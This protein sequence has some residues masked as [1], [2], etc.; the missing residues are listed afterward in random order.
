MQFSELKTLVLGAPAVN[1][2]NLKNALW[3]QLSVPTRG[4]STLR[5]TFDDTMAAKVM[6]NLRKTGLIEELEVNRVKYSVI[7]NLCFGLPYKEE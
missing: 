3:N 7:A 1:A 5:G 2:I 6:V 4:L